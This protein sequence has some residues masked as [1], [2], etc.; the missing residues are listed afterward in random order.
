MNLLEPILKSGLLGTEKFMPNASLLPGGIS[1][2]IAASATDREDAFLKT[3]A[4]AIWYTEAGSLPRT[5]GVDIAPCPPEPLP[6]TTTLRT[7]ILLELLQKNDLLLFA[8]F[9]NI[10]IADGQVMPP[11][12]VPPLLDLARQHKKLRPTL[13]ALAGITGQWL[14]GLNAYWQPLQSTTTHDVWQTGA[15]H[16]RMEYLKE[17]RA[18]DAPK[19]IELLNAGFEQ[20][21]AAARLA[22]VQVLHNHKCPEDEPFLQKLLADKS[23]P[24]KQEAQLL[25]KNL[26]GSALCNAYLNYATLLASVKEERY[27][28]LGRKKVLHIAEGIEPPKTLTETGLSK[29]SSLKGVADHLVWFAET[30]AHT[31]P[32]ALAQALQIDS[33]TLM[34]LLLAHKGL[35][36]LR[37]QLVMCAVNFN[38]TGWMRQLV[39]TGMHINA[40]MLQVVPPAERISHLQEL[41]KLQ[42]AEA[43]ATIEAMNFL[44]CNTKQ[45]DAYFEYLKS[46]PYHISK[47]DYQLLA[48]HMPTEAAATLHTFI[49]KHGQ[50]FNPPYFTDRVH[51]MLQVLQYK[52]QFTA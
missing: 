4:V 12:C 20:E 25:L 1:E 32:E 22:F 19:A 28:L 50:D 37:L 17:V 15:E 21:N 52:K 36:N 51:D 10:A 8:H 24:V 11:E 46:H 34:E 38:H 7:E 44:P 29:I 30:L 40:G 42:P 3:A 26:P 41:L 13:A 14:C 9:A 33:S 43:I 31:P 48:L 2:A 27:L 6:N 45:A 23:K 49:Q 18:L 16:E 39:A 47:R 35:E 5:T